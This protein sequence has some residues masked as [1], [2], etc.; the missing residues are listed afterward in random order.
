MAKIQSDVKCSLDGN[1]LELTLIPDTGTSGVGKFQGRYKGS[2][3]GTAWSSL[4]TFTPQ[5]SALGSDLRSDGSGFG[6]DY[7]KEGP[8]RWFLALVLDT[9]SDTSIWWS[10]DRGRTWARA[11]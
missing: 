1:L 7:A 11:S 2:G 3:D 4:P 8:A 10:A 9:E 6:F 5:N